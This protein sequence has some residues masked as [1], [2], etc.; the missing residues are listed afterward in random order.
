[1]YVVVYNDFLQKLSIV[2]LMCC[3][4]QIIFIFKYAFGNIIDSLLESFL[5]NPCWCKISFTE[6][7]SILLPKT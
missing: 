1:M 4:R 2:L 6:F 7:L 5:I 3:Y